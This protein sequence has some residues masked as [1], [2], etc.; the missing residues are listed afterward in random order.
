MCLRL[1]VAEHDRMPGS[2]EGMFTD[3]CNQIECLGGMRLQSWFLTDGHFVYLSNAGCLS[4]YRHIKLK[5]VCLSIWAPLESM[6]SQVA[7]PTVLQ[8]GPLG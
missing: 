7:R 8:F 6:A 5:N 4:W 1:L 3:S 2:T